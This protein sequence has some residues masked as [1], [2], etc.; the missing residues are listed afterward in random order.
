ME[1]SK[2]GINQIN[3][4]FPEVP[5]MRDITQWSTNATNTTTDHTPKSDESVTRH[6]IYAVAGIVPVIILVLV[7]FIIYFALKHRSSNMPSTVEVCLHS[8][9][10][11]QNGLLTRE[12]FPAVVDLPLQ[13][14][15]LPQ[16]EDRKCINEQEEVAFPE[17]DQ[18]QSSDMLKEAVYVNLSRKILR[19]E[20]KTYL[21]NVIQSPDLELEFRSVPA[22]MGKSC[23]EGALEANRCKNRYKNNIPYDDTRV[24]LP[25]LS[26]DPYSDYINASYI[27]GHSRANAF[28]ASQGPKDFNVDTIGDF[29]RMIWHTRSPI[30]IMVTNLIENGKV[31]V[32]QYWP[33]EGHP[34]VK[35]GIEIKLVST[36][37]KVDFI[38]RTLE[39]SKK[40][41]VREV[42]QYQYTAWPDHGVPQNPYGLAQMIKHLP[43]EP[44]TGPLIVHCSAG[45][46]R[47]GSVLLVLLMMDQLNS[48]GYLDPHQALIMLRNG[49]P[50]LVENKAQYIFSHQLLQEVLSGI[51]TSY[52]CD[53]FP[54]VVEDLR[55]PHPPSNTSIILQ[56]FQYLKSL[57]KDLSFKFGNNPR[58]AHLNRNLNI[59]PADKRMVFLQNLGGGLESQYINVVRVNGIDQKDAYLAGE[60]PL[61]H[62]V[63]NLWRLV[64]ERRV[65]VWIQLHTLPQHNLD[66][67]D[68]CSRE[69]QQTVGNM[70]ITV[71]SRHDF[72]NFIEY[73]VEVIALQSRLSVPHKCKLLMMKGWPHEDLLPA[74]P[75]PLLAIIEKTE[76]TADMQSYTLFTCK[77]G[78][79]GCGVMMALLLLV[80]R[81]KLVQEVD[82]YRSV[83]SVIYDRP[84]FITSIEQYDFLH[85]AAISYLNGFNNYVNFN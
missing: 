22:M 32:A 21:S 1:D 72:S 67:P 49:R 74:S 31:K 47:S 84:Q 37:N 11:C 51:T 10:Q 58:C 35:D 7:A 63:G 34:L 42:K 60:H 75:D 46:G 26:N 85:T 73:N 24:K 44:S 77:D 13:E 81:M 50:R 48:S 69:L 64:Y 54:E 78:V 57:P 8:P 80:A 5:Q 29:W 83:L 68:V 28:I 27:Q 25:F 36:E 39:V 20:V 9:I 38:I 33:E 62:T 56:Q 76:S 14:E 2:V 12:V 16:E 70:V 66:Y 82:V 30:I 65:P 40:M 43:K 4:G 6:M 79:T 19:T 3:T 55:L 15:I 45:I 41:E 23:S 53:K 59:L 61:P 71:I 18:Q 52:T 17:Q